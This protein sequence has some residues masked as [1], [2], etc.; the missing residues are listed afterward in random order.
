MIITTDKIASNSMQTIKKITE[1]DTDFALKRSKI[2][3]KLSADFTSVIMNNSFK[4]RIIDNNK[5][6]MNYENEATKLQFTEEK[7]K[8][9]SDKLSQ[10]DED[11]NYSEFASAAL[12]NNERVLDKYITENNNLKLQTDYA[13]EII[14][15]EKSKLDMEFKAIQIASQNLL[16]FNPNMQNKSTEDAVLK[17]DNFNTIDNDR[18]LNLVR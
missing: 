5:R 11:F 12:F 9:L 3:E 7:I 13:T 4:S 1:K 2:S 8:E 15:K 16:S 14:A 10:N 18:V 17:T 6:L